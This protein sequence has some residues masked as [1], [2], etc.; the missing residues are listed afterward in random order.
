M[1]VDVITP[2]D[3][4][5]HPP[6][7]DPSWQESYYFN[8]STADGAT[9]GLTR[10]GF[11]PSTRT[12]DALLIIVDEG[13]VSHVYPSVGTS[14]TPGEMT[15]RAER[16]LTVGNLTF[17]MRE[18]LTRWHI[19]LTGRVEVDLTF[20]ALAPPHD[21]PMPEASPDPQQDSR[22]SDAHH[23]EQTGRVHGWVSTGGHRRDIDALGQRDKSWGVRD[24]SAISG[25]DWITG[26]FGPDFAFN[27]TLSLVHDRGEPT[28]F[29]MRDG[30]NHALVDV[31]VDY[32]WTST[33]HVP[34]TARL[35]LV[36]EGGRAHRIHA[37]AL[38][39]VP[40]IKKGLFLQ[41]THARFDTELD[42][43]PRTGAGVMEHAWH[44]DLRSTLRRVPDLVPVLG[45]ALSGRIR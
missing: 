29:V 27:A 20:T 14:M 6:S 11:N 16:G 5:L 3:E 28:G 43:V 42:G 45:K 12:A 7:A 17:T 31:T 36:E 23:F 44:T 4:Q 25:W 13:R 8:W 32:Q 34:R 21:Y 26:Q 15:E 39:Q 37:T 30:V 18:P 33:P 10:I 41:E 9:F 38:T 22:T 19:R 1:R 40:L 2:L 24:W 35:T